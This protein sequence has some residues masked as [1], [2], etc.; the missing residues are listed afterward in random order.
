[1]NDADQF[2]LLKHRDGQKRPYAPKFDGCDIVRIALFNVG[3]FCR[4]IGDVNRRFGRYH[5]TEYS[6]RIRT[7]R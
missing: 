3:L 5:A 2:V 1:M 4:K 6:Y 7:K